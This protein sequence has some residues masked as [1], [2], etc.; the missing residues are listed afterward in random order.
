M[1]LISRS[2]SFISAFSTL[3]G[4]REKIKNSAAGLKEELNHVKQQLTTKRSDLNA[5]QD[6]YIRLEKAYLDLT[7]SANTSGNSAVTVD[8]KRRYITALE[9]AIERK[10]NNLQSLES[11]KNNYEVC[12]V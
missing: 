9:E 8:D 3:Q 7:R 11:T 5:V 4:E 1:F 6:E 12:L 10:R 2:T